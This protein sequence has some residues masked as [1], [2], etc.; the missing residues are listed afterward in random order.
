MRL[1]TLI[2]LGA[3]LSGCAG[4]QPG[5]RSHNRQEIPPGPGMLSGDDGQ[6]VIYRKKDTDSDKA[7]PDTT[8]KN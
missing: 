8:G 4:V 2:L 7:A 5:T 1:A 3:L 6:F